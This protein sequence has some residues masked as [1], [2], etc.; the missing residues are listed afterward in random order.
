M[1]ILL[2]LDDSKTSQAATD[3]VIRE[4][5]PKQNEVCV[6]HVVEPLLLIPYYYIGEIPNLESAQEKRTSEGREFIRGIEQQFSKAGYKVRTE[7]KVGD[8]RGEILDFAAVWNPDLI[9][10]GSHGRK[11]LDRLLIGSVAE[12][13]GRHAVCSVLVARC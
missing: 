10:V 8:P 9:V 6:L 5:S 2:A 4:M 1:K 12:T 13:V 11:G 3:L 7:L